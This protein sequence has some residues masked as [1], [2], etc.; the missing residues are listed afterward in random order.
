MSLFNPSKIYQQL[1][2]NNRIDPFV[3]VAKGERCQQAQRIARIAL[4]FIN[5]Y[6]PAQ[7]GLAVTF[8]S[9]NACV[10]GAQLIQSAKQHEWKVAM[11][12]ASC[13]ALTV[14][15]VAITIL[16]PAAGAALSSAMQIVQSFYKMSCHL[17]EGNYK[18]AAEQ[19]ARIPHQLI[20]MGAIVYGTPE[21]LF[22]SLLTQGCIELYHSYREWR[23]EGHVPES[24]ASLVMALL[25]IYQASD[26]APTLHRN[27]FGHQI[28]QEDLNIIIKEILQQK[29]EHPGELVDFET[30]LK[31]HYYSSHLQ[32]L[33]FTSDLSEIFFK[34]IAF[35][36]CNFLMNNFSHSV[37]QRVTAKNSLFFEVDFS[38]SIFQHFHAENC[39]FDSPQSSY[40]F[41][42]QTTF[43]KSRF[44][45]ADFYDSTFRQTSF[46][47]CH[48]K[49]ANMTD[50]TFRQVRFADCDLPF[51]NFNSS[52]LSQTIFTRSNLK[53]T[54]FFDAKVLNSLLKDCNLTDCLLLD[55]QESFHIEGGT[56]LRLTKPII[57][58][59]W[60]FQQHGTFT[61]MTHKALKD[62]GALVLKFN[63]ALKGAD[64]DKLRQEVENGIARINQNGLK[65]SQI[66]IAN[67]LIQDSAGKEISR[68]KQQADKVVSYVQGIVL[69]GGDDVEPEFY[70][71]NKTLE[72]DNNYQR[73]L[74]EF[75]A[76]ASTIKKG[77]PLQGICRG[78]QIV[79]VFKGG[80]LKNHI[81]KHYEVIHNLTINKDCPQPAAAIMQKIIGGSQ[82]HG[83][84]M[85]HQAS[86][87]IG[88][89]LHVVL[90]QEGSPEALV[91]QD[92]KIVLTQFHPEAYIV[93]K[94][95]N[96]K[97]ARKTNNAFLAALAT[98]DLAKGQNFFHHIIQ[99]AGQIAQ[100]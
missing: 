99:Q 80:T 43:L 76:I 68:I 15:Q 39:C 90:E 14:N 79:N 38:N 55:T 30:I 18:Q 52:N 20:Y 100:V 34:N 6:K 63:Y 37:F 25:R 60:N 85:H 59:L 47:D 8:G 41:F 86:Q 70:Q 49:G 65:P 50:S 11:M 94:Q 29:D 3:Q 51:T 12:H 17:K 4:P 96:K 73:T 44:R 7:A 1:D 53:E 83:V 64:C 61:D 95:L 23:T 46:H 5:L 98:M 19:F 27:Y 84:S 2:F 78:A 81:D 75:S 92:G 77:I 35:Q 32:D 89:G 74:F 33:T 62:S 31:N 58:L 45:K 26:H 22:L 9:I 48:I 72:S 21:F 28:Q 24:L 88:Q 56:P 36:K 93:A 10:L 66:S 91:S 82:I 67:A 54:C 57:G 71:A 13:I 42:D 87:R 16:M 69:P 40:S 97:S